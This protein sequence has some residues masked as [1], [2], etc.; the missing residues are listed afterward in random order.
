M[1]KTLSEKYWF[2][3]LRNILFVL[4]IVGATYLG[5]ALLIRLSTNWSWDRSFT[6]T[7]VAVSA[8]LTVVM[9]M[10]LVRRNA[11]KEAVLYDAGKHPHQ[12]IFK[13]NLV[14]SVA[15]VILFLLPIG[16]DKGLFE[17]AAP[18]LFFFNGL[19]AIYCLLGRLQIREEGI[20]YYWNLIPW[21]KI[22]SY[23]WTEK[24]HLLYK[25]DKKFGPRQGILVIPP[26]DRDAFETHLVKHVQPAG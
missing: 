1:F 4:P 19:F 9:L 6:L 5:L 20:Q 25:V 22:A 21:S 2:V 7:L 16:G 23:K 14:I 26:K 8:L 24:S 17:L 12:G 11:K 15:M 10:Q 3:G 18:F 13:F